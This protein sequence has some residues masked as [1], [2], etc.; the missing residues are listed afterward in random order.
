MLERYKTPIFLAVLTAIGVGVLML[1][2]YRP[3]PVVIQII[4]PGPTATPRPSATPGPIKVYITGAV[5]SATGMYSLPAGSRVDD[6]IKAAGGFRPEA[7]RVRVNLAQ[8]LSD[9]DQIHVPVVGSESAGRPEITATRKATATRPPPININTATREQLQSLPGIGPKTAQDILD[10]RANNGPF[11][12]PD[13]LD[14]VAGIGPATLKELE[15][16]IAFDLPSPTAT[17]GK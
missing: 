7:D 15:G 11:L 1:L 8:P 12:T 13:D 9:G 6:A 14:K 10:Y 2:A 5:M 16:L 4:P 17:P 3:P